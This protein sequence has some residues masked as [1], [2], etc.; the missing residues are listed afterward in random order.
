MA[1]TSPAMTAL[2]DSVFNGVSMEQVTAESWSLGGEIAHA[3]FPPNELS[4]P[5]A[6]LLFPARIAPT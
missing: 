6:I 4:D 2:I 1:G 3:S 5:A